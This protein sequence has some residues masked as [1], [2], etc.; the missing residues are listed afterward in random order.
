MISVLQRGFF[1]HLVRSV[2]CVA[3]SSDQGGTV[4]VEIGLAPMKA[5]TIWIFESTQ[6]VTACCERAIS[7][8]L[9]SDSLVD[10]C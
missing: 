8:P 9:P 6:I 5:L 2:L 7:N 1:H 4:E 10:E 3:L